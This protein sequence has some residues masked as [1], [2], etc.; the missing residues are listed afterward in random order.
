MPLIRPSHAAH[1]SPPMSDTDDADDALD[2]RIDRARPYDRGA[3]VACP[4]EPK[5]LGIDIGLQAEKRQ[6]RLDIGDATVGCQPAAR[7]FAGTPALVVE[8]QDD[9]AGIVEHPGVVGKIEIL[10]TRVAMT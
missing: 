1:P 5:T 6:R 7:P 8:G 4:V 2:A 3:A 10:H 9:I